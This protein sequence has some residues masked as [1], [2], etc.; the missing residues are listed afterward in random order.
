MR[1]FRL[2]RNY[3]HAELLTINIL[4]LRGLTLHRCQKLSVA[5]RLFQ[6]FEHDFHLFGWRQR[7]E[8]ATHHPDA[9]EVIFRNQQLFLARS[10]TLQV[11]R[12][13]QSL[14]AQAAVEMNFAITRAF[15][16]FKDDIIHAG[17]RVDER[18]GDD[19]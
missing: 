8:Y 12:R 9:A 19:R 17:A 15:E 10:G 4:P 3:T 7:I 11:D 6:T 2:L 14:V 1:A 16:L 5:L 18:G 13:E